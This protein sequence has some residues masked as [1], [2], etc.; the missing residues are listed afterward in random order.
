M[1]TIDN[2]VQYAVS[3]T[4]TEAPD[5]EHGTVSNIL[6]TEVGKSLGGSGTALAEEYNGTAAV[7]GYLDAAANYRMAPDGA[8]EEV[9]ISSESAASFVFIKHSGYAI[10]SDNASTLGDAC[11]RSLKV[12][13]NAG[14]IILSIL[15]AGEAIILKDDN[16]TI[17]TSGIEVETVDNDGTETGSLAHIAVEYLVVNNTD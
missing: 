9:A 6:A 15:D 12:T 4:P 17:D 3:C 16:G 5:V 1:A 7:Q 13:T 10:T 2:T 11:A 8:G 14:A